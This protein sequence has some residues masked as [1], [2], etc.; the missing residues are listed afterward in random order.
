MPQSILESLPDQHI[1]DSLPDQDD[2]KGILSRVW[3]V[4]NTPLVKQNPVAEQA[5]QEFS[6]QHPIIGGIGKFAT[7]AMLSLSSPL[8]L[9]L[10]ATTGGASVAEKAGM[11]GLASGLEI[12]GKIAASGMVGHG[13]YNMYEQP[14]IGGK[15]GGAVEA[16][17]GALGLHG[18]LH[19]APEPEVGIQ[20]IDF[21]VPKTPQRLALPEANN[22]E[23]TRTF[24]GG[25]PG[26]TGQVIDATQA[27]QNP[28]ARIRIAGSGKTPDAAAQSV[29]LDEMREQQRQQGL[30]Y[31]AA[32]QYPGSRMPISDSNQYELPPISGDTTGGF[33]EQTNKEMEWPYNVIPNSLRPRTAQSEILGSTGLKGIDLQKPIESGGGIHF[34]SGGVDNPL[35]PTNEPTPEVATGTGKAYELLHPNRREPISEI[36]DNLPHQQTRKPLDI[37]N[38]SPRLARSRADINSIPAGQ[39]DAGPLISPNDAAINEPTLGKQVAMYNS[40]ENS[41]NR[42]MAGDVPNNGIAQRLEAERR[43]IYDPTTSQQPLPQQPQKD[44][45]A[46]RAEFSSPHVVMD[47]FSNSRSVIQPIMQANDEKYKWLATI[48][49][50]FADVSKGFNGVARKGLTYLLNGEEPVLEGSNIGISVLRQQAEQ[51]RNLLDHVW[52]LANDKSPE[53]VGFI[54]R[55]ITHIKAQPEDFQSAVKS[56]IENQFGKESGLYKI[57]ST[58]NEKL[59]TDD[60]GDYYETGIGSPTSNFIKTRK[61]QLQD[62]ETDYNRIIP[63]YLESMAKVIHDRPATDIAKEALEEIPQGKL[64]EYLTGYIKNYTRYDADAELAQAWNGLANQIATTNARSVIAFNPLVHIYHAGQLPANVWPELG[65]KYSMEGTKQFLSNPIQS[66]QELA[67]NGLFSNMI[68]PMQF[69]T[70]MQKFDTI[71][72]YMNMVESIVKGIGYYGFKARALDQGMNDLDATMHAITQTKN[73]TATVDP[74]RNMRYF[75]PE[76]NILGGQM[77]RIAKQYHQIPVKL[78][79]QFARA[80]SD[81][82]QNPA[83]AARYIA[84]TAIAGAGAVTGLHTLHVNPLTLGGTVLGGAGQLGTVMTSVIR[85]LAKGDLP[86]ALGDIATWVTPGGATAKKGIKLISGE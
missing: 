51:A 59:P 10:A 38:S 33:N 82:K 73:A 68:R 50:E 31:T 71:S 42:G 23:L 20:G 16:G 79:E 53:G 81:F 75:T 7:D 84:G 13:A 43:G 66:Y 15:A 37:I 35:F 2:K 44:I 83:K 47:N 17:L 9:G 11:S 32:E 65:T 69:Q 62:I 54:D 57:F 74:A 45:S 58:N 28:L 78:V 55:Y 14:T 34:V 4:I 8:T 48:Q 3:E 52:E 39:A 6:K 27:E 40:I 41:N 49:R 61:G 86:G 22:P 77:P 1:L 60:I 19:V 29:N 25:E 56:I 5:Q 12:P 76:S 24:L 70:P 21:P 36:L 85:N 72:Y 46:F 67:K 80:A 18:G 63:T 30:T 26:A 64:K